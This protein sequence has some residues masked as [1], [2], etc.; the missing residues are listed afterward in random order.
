MDTIIKLEL[1]I[2]EVNFVLES[3]GEM[4]SK[5]I[6]GFLMAKIKEQGLPQ[7]PDELKPKED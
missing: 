5:T 4:P 3:L 2:A 6:A 7:V 1:S